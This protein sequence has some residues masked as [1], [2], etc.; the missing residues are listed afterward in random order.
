M[1]NPIQHNSTVIKADRNRIAQVISNL[2]D[3]AIKFTKEGGTVS[4][5]VEKENDNWIMVSIQDTGIGIDPEIMPRL[6]SK[7]V[8]RSQQGTG[9]GLFISK[10]IIEAHGGRIWA[11]NN[12]DGIGDYIQFQSSIVG[13]A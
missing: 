2:T 11:E 4:I 13:S 8:T 3:N 10:G 5:N 9:L 1:Y 6:F 12:I 7:F